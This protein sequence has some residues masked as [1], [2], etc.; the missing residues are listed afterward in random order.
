MEHLPIIS[1]SELAKDDLD[2]QEVKRLYNACYECGFFYL[3]DHGVSTLA[4]EQTIEA[5]KNFFKLPE[6]IK[7][8]YGHDI[9]KV[10]PPTS[11]GYVPLHGEYLNE[12]TGFDPKEVFDL[13]LDKPL[14]D[15]PFTGPNIMP[16]S[17]VAPG[18]ATSHYNLQQEIMIK[19][20]PKLLRGISL[21]LGLKATWFDRYFSDPILIHRTI[22]YPQNSGKAGKHTDNGIFTVLIQ[23]QLPHPSLRVH[24]KD[25]WI[26]VPC[27]EN[28]FIIN[29]GDMLQMWTDG[30]FVSTPHEVIHT[31]STSR[32]SIPFFVYPNIDT[33]IEPFGK[34]K[35]ISAKEVML[36]NFESIWVNY[37]GAGRSRELK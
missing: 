20:V 25:K 1:L 14:S 37:K 16:D 27:L 5:S 12:E 24:T 35:K 6:Q 13:G 7:R 33:I 22:Y 30:L 2:N 18:F 15:K 26:D 23:E 4:I 36:K 11:R 21:A 29:L 3:K 17:T 9:Q 31:F 34:D 32:I 28:T 19:V 10:Y 8:N